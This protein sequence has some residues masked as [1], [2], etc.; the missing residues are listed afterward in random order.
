MRK[1]FINKILQHQIK[2]FVLSLHYN[3]NNSYLFVNGVQKLK[4]KAKDSEIKR[5]ILYF[6]NMFWNI[7]VQGM[8][9][10][11]D[12]MKKFMILLLIINQSIV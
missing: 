11:L 12:Y 4:S 1:R 9:Q 7:G 6:G 10:R 3:G 5:E 8:Q 2:K